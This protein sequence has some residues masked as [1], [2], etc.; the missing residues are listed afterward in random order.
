MHI[1]ANRS[2]RDSYLEIP[3]SCL[4]AAIHFDFNKSFEEKLKKDKLSPL[5][6]R[7]SLLQK[8]KQQWSWAMLNTKPK[9]YARPA[10]ILCATQPKMAL[11]DKG[12]L[13]NILCLILVTLLVYRH[14]VLNIHLTF[15][16]LIPPGYEACWTAQEILACAQGRGSYS[17]DCLLCWFLV[18]IF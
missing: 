8:L 7:L 5:L 2:R 10:S 13:K 1:T 12:V 4:V 9:P 15:N 17:V 16:Q 14:L 3:L 11:R 18:D 6:F